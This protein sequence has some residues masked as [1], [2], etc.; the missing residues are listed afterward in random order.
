MR[1]SAASSGCCNRP[2]TTPRATGIAQTF[3]IKLNRIVIIARPRVSYG[4]AAQGGRTYPLLPNFTSL[5]AHTLNSVRFR[6]SP[7]TATIPP[8]TIASMSTAAA[9]GQ[10]G[11]QRIV[12]GPTVRI[13]VIQ[14][15]VWCMVV[16]KGAV[17]Q[18]GLVGKS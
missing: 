2:A 1:V 17:V 11:W 9:V 15:K 10:V 16:G 3:E 8:A 12:A 5:D 13:L 14:V 7:S 4:Q 6:G 18:R